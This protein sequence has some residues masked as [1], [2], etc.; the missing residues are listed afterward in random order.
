MK[1]QRVALLTFMLYMTEYTMGLNV[2]TENIKLRTILG[3]YFYNPF[4]FFIT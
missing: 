2:C 3:C 1:E 4:K